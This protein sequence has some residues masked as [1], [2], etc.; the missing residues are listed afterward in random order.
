MGGS[1]LGHCLRRNDHFYRRFLEDGNALE[2]GS[3]SAADLHLL[4]WRTGQLMA[5]HKAGSIW[6]QTNLALLFRALGSQSRG[7]DT[8]LGPCFRAGLV[9]GAV[10]SILDGAARCA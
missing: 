9:A 10:T 7:V 4:S 2:R 1:R 8:G 6:K 5:G 3:H